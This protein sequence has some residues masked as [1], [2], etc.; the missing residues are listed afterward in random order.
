MIIKMMHFLRRV[1]AQSVPASPGRG[2]PLTGVRVVALEHSVA[3]PL[4]SR[5]LR[6][7]GAEVVKVEH[8]HGDFARHWDTNVA[9]DC[10][11]FWWLNRGKKSAMLNLREPGDREVFDELLRKA[12]VFVHNL[13]PPSATRLGL[14]RASLE[15]AYPHLINCQISGYGASGRSVNR[16]A[17]DMLVQAESG[18]MSLTG[19]PEQPM[20]TGVSISD[21]ST[22]LY[23]SL[24]ILGA[25]RERDR[26]L[27]GRYL[28][29]AM[30]DATLEFL[31]PMLISY[32]N[33]GVV[34]PRLPDRHHAIAPYGAFECKDGRKLVIAIEQ[35]MEWVRFCTAV[36]GVPGLAND[37]RFG[38]NLDRLENRVELDAI[39]AELIAGIESDA[40]IEGLER[41]G[42]AYARINDISSVAAHPA[43]EDRRIIDDF[44]TANGDRIRSHVGL[45]ER[46]FSAHDRR[47]R[48][49]PPL[50]GE[51]TDEVTRH[52]EA[53]RDFHDVIPMP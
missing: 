34:Y 33:A 18:V 29:V 14:N 46:T 20:R 4:T 43:V 9:G 12:D 51:D 15:R 26:T 13:A 5:I 42:L 32:L 24:L 48:S 47:Q 27:K 8:D 44:V 2:G 53:S 37:L 3:G 16:K 19:T 1:R 40:L 28:D 41:A 38:R 52:T 7:F 25:L 39:L 50:P 45:V 21:V 36:L 23:A 49:R 6:E 35:D 17:Y 22:G 10:A 30:I 31:G 11:Q